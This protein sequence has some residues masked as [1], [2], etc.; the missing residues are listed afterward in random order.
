MLKK[1]IYSTILG[2]SV[3]FSGC[4]D[5]LEES[6]SGSLPSDEAITSVTDLRNAVNGVY[7]GMIDF[8]LGLGNETE[9][10]SYYGGDFIAYADLKGGDLNYTSSN[11]QISPMARYEHGAESDFAEHFWQMPYTLSGRINDI[12]S[13]ADQVEI[14]TGETERFNDLKGQLFALRALMHFDLARMFA[15]LPSITEMNVPNSGIPLSNQKFPVDY[16]PERA[17]L[18]ETYDFIKGDLIQALALLSKEQ[19]LGRFNYWSAKG[20]LA[21]VHL[22]LGENNDALAAAQEVI[23]DSPYALYTREEY[24][25][26]WNQEGTSESMFEILTNSSYNSQRNS[27]GYYTHS[28]GYGEAAFSEQGYLFMTSNPA[29]VR[30]QLIEWE[31]DQPDTKGFY[32]QKYPG[33]NGDLYLNNPKVIRLSEVYLIAAE[34]KVKGG[35][36]AGDRSAAEYINALR[37]NR[38]EGYADVASVTLDDVLDE[39]RKELAAEGHRNWDAW[40]NGKSIY[41]PRLNREIDGHFERAILPIPK[42]ERD[43]SPKLVQNPGY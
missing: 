13:V 34:A 24:L 14:R 26:V 22:Y 42:R 40:R 8:D 32:T 5:F 18:K 12:L 35:S 3:V 38:I 7:S 23:S 21:R 25:T 17:T 33:R 15:K 1:I 27:I 2:M 29:D 37:R 16:E 31:E 19:N 4:E 36:A 11:N 28:D 20:L 41:S 43:I 9:P 6:P 30:A 10:F 39:R